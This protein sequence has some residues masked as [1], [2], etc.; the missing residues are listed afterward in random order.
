[1]K[2]LARIVQTVLVFLAIFGTLFMLSWFFDPDPH[3]LP[4]EV[5]ADMKPNG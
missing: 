4:P 2:S 5:A 1:M 3:S